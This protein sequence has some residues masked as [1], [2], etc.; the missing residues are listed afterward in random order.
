MFMKRRN[1]LAITA[2]LLLQLPLAAIGATKKPTPKATKKPPIKP[3]KKPPTPTPTP[4]QKPSVSPTPQILP[5]LREGEL[6]KL[7]SLAAPISF[8]A[9]VTK[10]NVEYPL[11]VSKPTERTIK[12]FTARCPHQGQILNLAKLG[13]FT[14]DRHSARFNEITGKVT[15]GPTIQNLE[16]Y[17]LIERNGLMYISF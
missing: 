2:G 8:Y 13:E 15:Q 1:F 11:L 9:S 10:A 14:C 5:V 17:E 3:T 7:E 12:I 6:I 16:H 4:I